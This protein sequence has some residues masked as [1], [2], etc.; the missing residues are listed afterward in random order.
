ML[1]YE[2]QTGET[3]FKENPMVRCHIWNPVAEDCVL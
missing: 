3:P 2:I 1:M